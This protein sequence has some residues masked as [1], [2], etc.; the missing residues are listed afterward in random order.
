MNLINMTLIPVF[1]ALYYA[2][3]RR[4]AATG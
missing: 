2:L 1:L 4:H 3:I